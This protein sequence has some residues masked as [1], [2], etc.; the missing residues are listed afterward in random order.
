M[1]IQQF[2]PIHW[3][4]TLI[5]VSLG[6]GLGILFDLV[7]FISQTFVGGVD[8]V[9][10]KELFEGAFGMGTLAV[11]VLAVIFA[12][13]FHY[14]C[15]A[16]IPAEHR[17]T[18]PAK[19]VGFLFI[20]FYNFYWV[21]VSFR[22]L[23]IDVNKYADSIGRE[24]LKVCEHLASALSILLLLCMVSTAFSGL[25]AL[26]VIASYVLWII[27]SRKLSHVIPEM[28]SIQSK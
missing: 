22:G 26:V 25:Y 12:A 9:S 14:R 21:F 28:Q 23:A 15:W 24:D 16:A 11:T 7:V 5:F 20:P 18:S 10:G 27:Y 19:A 3:C 17:R 2:K 4:R 6:L 8:V 13:I 1:D